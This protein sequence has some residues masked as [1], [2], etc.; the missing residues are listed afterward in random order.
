MIFIS[1]FC[2]TF[3]PPRL[4]P[5][6][7]ICNN[8]SEGVSATSLCESSRSQSSLKTKQMCSYTRNNTVKPAPFFKL[9]FSLVDTHTGFIPLLLAFLRTVGERE[10]QKWAYRAF[11]FYSKKSMNQGLKIPA[12]CFAYA[13]IVSEM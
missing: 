3:S 2:I 11:F 8:R 9:C 1:Y 10:S 6:I 4:S 13:T 7:V 12:G 5:V